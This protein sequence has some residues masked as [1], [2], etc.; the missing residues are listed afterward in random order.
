MAEGNVTAG[1]PARPH[2]PGAF[3]RYL[4]K[5]RGPVGQALADQEAQR[6]TENADGAMAAQLDRYLYGPIANFTQQGGKRTRPIICLLGCEAVGG[7]AERALGCAVAIEDFQSAALV[8]DDIADDGE[9]RR[10][11]PCLHLTQGVGLAINDGDLAL[12]RV[13]GTVLR[14]A[15]LDEACKL[16]VLSE[17]DRMMLR[18]LEGQALDLGW[19]RDARWDVTP[20]DYRFMASHKTAHYSAATP[21][22]CGAIIGG[23]TEEQVEGLRAFGMDAGLAFQLQDDL[24]N[25]VGDAA[26]QGKDFRSDITEGK[27]TLAVVTALDRLGGAS[28][29]ELVEIL[30][31]H[32]SDPARQQQA[33]DLMEE[34]GAIDAVREEAMALAKRASDR[35]AG[36]ELRPE[37]REVLASMAEFFVE[38]IS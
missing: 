35:L 2:E 32:T 8:H 19:A 16:R 13:S 31:S 29:G 18:T 24:L 21:L 25:L 15:G 12:V 22:A 20:D 5:W 3:E 28:R 34:V 23:G 9:L 6:P 26:S 30:S 10:G 38:R 27:R 1:T 37:A 14:D 4:A 36:I 17:L 7:E 11:A 33:V